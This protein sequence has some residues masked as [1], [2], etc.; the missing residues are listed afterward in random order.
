MGEDSNLKAVFYAVNGLSGEMKPLGKAQLGLTDEENRYPKYAKGGIKNECVAFAEIGEEEYSG[1]L[2]LIVMPKTMKKKRFIKLIMSKG[3]QRN[4]ANKIHQEYMEKYKY[5]TIY[6]RIPKNN[7]FYGKEISEIDINVHGGITY[8]E[9]GLHIG[10]EK[11]TEGWYIGWDYAHYG[12]YIGFEEKYPILC[13]TGGKKW[14]TNEIFIEIREVCYQ[15]QLV[16]N[17]INGRKL[18]LIG[19]KDALIH[20]LSEV[21]MQEQYIRRDIEL[22]DK[23]IK[24]M[25]AGEK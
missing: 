22:I 20:S 15:I 8:S 9:E 5:R 11:A 12:D 7:K 3:Y 25:D 10:N 21:K 24:K 2:N 23:E 6:V 17:Q 13:R 14:T 19:Q 18:Y 4:K 1:E 16:S